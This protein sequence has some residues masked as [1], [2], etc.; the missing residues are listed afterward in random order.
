MADW[1]G[2]ISVNRQHHPKTN[3]KNKA[4]RRKP[5]MT[6]SEAEREVNR[7]FPQTKV[8]KLNYDENILSS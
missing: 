6:F 4:R 2:I 1:E 5:S 7:L 8:S 3:H